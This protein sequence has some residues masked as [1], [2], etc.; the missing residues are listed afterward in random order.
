MD[1]RFISTALVY[2]LD[3]QTGQIVRLAEAQHPLDPTQTDCP[4]EIDFSGYQNF[5]GIVVPT[6]VAEKFLGSSVWEFHLSGIAFNQGV[7]DSEFAL[8]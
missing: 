6:A 1:P 7:L 5:A 4:H 8:D 3:A 2:F